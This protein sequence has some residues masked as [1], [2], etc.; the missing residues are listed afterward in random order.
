MPN[1]ISGGLL[2]C[3]AAPLLAQ[4]PD[5]FTLVRN[6]CQPCHN[7]QVRSSGLALDSRADI[8]RGGNRGPAVKTDAPDGSLLV[9]AIVQTGDLA[10]PPGRKLSEEQI[11]A[12]RKWIVDGMAFPQQ[13]Q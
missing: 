6:N 10:M 4:A 9:R 12:I 1:L 13:A 2:L 5:G 3:C 8:L 11:A 7:Q